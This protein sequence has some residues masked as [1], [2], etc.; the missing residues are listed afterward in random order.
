MVKALGRLT[1]EVAVTKV[2]I[3]GVEKNVLN[4][5]IAMRNSNNK[6]ETTFTDITAWD[7][8]ADLIGRFFNKGDEI[9]LT[10]ELRNRKIEV[11]GKK[12]TT[13]YI[14]VEKFEFTNGNK[15][16]E[17]VENPALEPNLE[18]WND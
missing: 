6:N 1:R 4:N 9:L 17:E 2:N 15:K 18:Y 5:A 8:T 12:I 3:N 11:E 16:K 10:G 7:G 14:L 13:C